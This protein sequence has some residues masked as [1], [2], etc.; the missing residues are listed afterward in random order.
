MQTGKK[1]K[2]LVARLIGTEKRKDTF[3]QVYDW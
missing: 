3:K 2:L 1:R